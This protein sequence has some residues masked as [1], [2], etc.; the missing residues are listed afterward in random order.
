[1]RRPI[2]DRQLQ[3]LLPLCRDNSQRRTLRRIHHLLVK[4]NGAERKHDAM[5]LTVS[6]VLLQS[7][8][9]VSVEH[10]IVSET[11][12]LYADVYAV[13]DGVSKIYEVEVFAYRGNF[14]PVPGSRYYRK[15]S[16]D[17]YFGDRIIGKVSRYWGYADEVYLVYALVNAKYLRR[18]AHLFEFFKKPINKR[19]LKTIQELT[20]GVGNVYRH[21]RIPADRIKNARLNGVYGVDIT[22]ARLEKLNFDLYAVGEI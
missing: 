9:E 8:H 6:Y 2:L 3:R 15:L 16:K 20:L 12:T 1:M 18:Y 13:K 17:E 5:V 19:S 11:E 14:V 10:R 4:K 22:N 21:P 7:S